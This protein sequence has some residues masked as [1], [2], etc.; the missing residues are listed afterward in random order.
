MKTRVLPVVLF[1][2]L[3]GG[4][5]GCLVVVELRGGGGVRRRRRVWGRRW[6][7]TPHKRLTTTRERNANHVPP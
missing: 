5:W 7:Q 4:G 2:G 6:L 3:F 1:G